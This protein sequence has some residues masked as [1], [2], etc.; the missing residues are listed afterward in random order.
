MTSGSEPLKQFGSEKLRVQFL[1]GEIHKAVKMKHDHDAGVLKRF[2]IVSRN[3]KSTVCSGAHKKKIHFVAA[4]LGF[5]QNAHGT[6]F[7]RRFILTV[8]DEDQPT[9]SLPQPV[10]PWR[11]RRRIG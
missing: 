5:L 8:C 2:A 7:I 11:R 3:S 6:L 10:L 4:L 1:V 9:A